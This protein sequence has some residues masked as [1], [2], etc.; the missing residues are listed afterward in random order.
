MGGVTE[1]ATA[2]PCR[3]VTSDG[4]GIDAAHTPYRQTGRGAE[5][6]AVVLAHGFTGT[7]RSRDTRRIA[8]VLSGYAGVLSFDFRGHGRSGGH[9]TVGDQEIHDIEAVVRHARRIGYDRVAVVGFSMGAACAVRHAALMGGVDAVVA[10]SGPS[11]WY[12]RDT[13]PMR[14]VHWAIERPEGRL[15][16]RVFKRTRILS[17]GWD[18]VPEEPREVISRIAPAPVLI[19]HG[20]ADPFFPLEHAE[21][22][23]AAAGE[24]R[25]LWVE[26]GYGHA[27]SAASPALIHRLGRWVTTARPLPAVAPEPAAPPLGH[28]LAAG[29]EVAPC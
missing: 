8:H 20:D 29:P 28:G 14:Q 25:E 1:L 18:P 27:E 22:L 26:P 4:V 2:Y 10:V 15:L 12:Y 9:S 16:A 6:L 13:A 5:G 7:W 19:V 11:R 23:H 21:Q 3:L 24:P 17:R